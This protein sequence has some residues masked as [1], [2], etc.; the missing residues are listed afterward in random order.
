MRLLISGYNFY[1][2]SVSLPKAWRKLRHELKKPVAGESIFLDHSGKA[3]KRIQN[4]R[5][6][7][8][9]L[10]TE[11]I[12]ARKRSST[13]VILG[14][15]AS[16]NDISDSQWQ[17]IA[18]HD[19]IG[20]NFWFVHSFV[21][22]FYHVEYLR[23]QYELVNYIAIMKG[24][25]KRYREVP[26]LMSSNTANTGWHPKYRPEVF[27]RSVK[28]FV[29]PQFI[30]KSIPRDRAIEPSDFGDLTVNLGEAPY[31]ARG[32]L[33]IVVHI[34]FQMK[35]DRIILAGIDLNNRGYF[36]DDL[37]CMKWKT[38]LFQKK[39]GSHP[40]TV[41]S[42]GKYHAVDTFLPAFNEIVLKPNGTEL[43]IASKSSLL[44]PSLPHHPLSDEV[45]E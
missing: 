45:S 9:V 30:I 20:F 21:P 38:E 27:P 37:D 16:I 35:Y 17:F 10:S 39:N 11:D 29:Y 15:G 2:G 13:L 6:K 7:Y 26:F 14:S 25:E 41:W 40:I 43:F 28:L 33:T 23:D 22:T 5:V 12:M 42:G 4:F 1:K 8:T 18:R 31:I 19:S 34:G 3:I 44:Y 32:S 36:Y 24:L